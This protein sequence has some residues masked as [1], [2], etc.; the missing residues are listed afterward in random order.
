[1]YVYLYICRYVFGKCAHTFDSVL[2]LYCIVFFYVNTLLVC[3][4]IKHGIEL[5]CNLFIYTANKIK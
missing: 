2:L 3:L 1:M 4:I 5:N